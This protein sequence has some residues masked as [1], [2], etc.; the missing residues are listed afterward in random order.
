MTIFNVETD[1]ETSSYKIHTF[2]LRNK[3]LH[4]TQLISI[5][6]SKHFPPSRHIFETRFSNITIYLKLL[7]TAT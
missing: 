5:L 6:A 2:M 1:A 4:K 7:H 3:T